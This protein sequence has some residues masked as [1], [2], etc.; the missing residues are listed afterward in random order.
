VD[1]I[2][3]EHIKEIGMLPGTRK[4]LKS[5]IKTF[6]REQKNEYEIIIKNKNKNN[7]EIHI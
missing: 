7:Q 1:A 2:T 3:T 6:P 5:P 4:K